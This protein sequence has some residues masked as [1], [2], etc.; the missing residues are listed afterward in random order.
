MLRSGP[1]SR[2]THPPLSPRLGA[3]LASLE[4]SQGAFTA[5]PLATVA[6]HGLAAEA[7]PSLMACLRQDLQH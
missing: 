1:H 7:V 2:G 4:A 5:P 3:L 6:L